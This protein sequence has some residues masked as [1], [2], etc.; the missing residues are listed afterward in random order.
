MVNLIIALISIALI[1][2]IAVSALYSGGDAF[3]DGSADAK[4]NQIMNTG[5]Q[6]SAA[7]EL[8]FLDNDEFAVDV[9]DL[10]TDGKYLREDPRLP[11]GVSLSLTEPTEGNIT[12]TGVS[13]SVCNTEILD[14]D[15]DKVDT[16]TSCDYDFS[17]D[18]VE[19]D[20]SGSEGS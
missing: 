14:S 2:I 1:A 7:N 11:D 16:G 9:V 15:S 17:T 18:T 10:T 6:V 19:A 3:R 4:A 20:T 13:A 5:Q 8:Y 12:F